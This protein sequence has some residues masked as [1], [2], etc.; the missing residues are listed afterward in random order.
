MR[1]III[2]ISAFILVSC[3]FYTPP[4]DG[5]TA[6][7]KFDGNTQYAY[8]DTASTAGRICS[9]IPLVRG[10][11]LRSQPIPAGRRLWIQQGIDT[12]GLAFGMSCG[13]VYSFVP[14]QGA[15]YIS[16]YK[17]EGRRCYLRL[18]KKLESGTLEP[19]ASYV[20]EPK[21]CW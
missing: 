5:P 17:L 18:S 14:D 16:E 10:E 8:I 13:F 21:G 7:I 1:T 3:A 19:V 6:Q 15:I 2:V 9:S 11:G 20:R 12:M 4:N